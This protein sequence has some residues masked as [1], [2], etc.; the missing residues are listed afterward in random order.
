[1]SDNDTELVFLGAKFAGSNWLPSV[2]LC[3]LECYVFEP[4]K[5]FAL[6]VELSNV[7][8]KTNSDKLISIK[9][10]FYRID[11]FRDAS[12]FLKFS[13]IIRSIFTSK[14][15]LNKAKLM[16][17]N[18]NVVVNTDLK[19]VNSCTNWKIIIK[20]I[21]VDLSKSAIKAVFSKFGKIISIRMQLIDLWQKAVVEFKSAEIVCLV[22]FKWSVLVEKNSVHVAL[23]VNDKESWISRDF[24]C[25]LLYT[26]L[27][28]T[29]AHNLSDL[30][31][32]Y[33][34]KTCVIGHNFISYVRV[35]CAVI[36]FKSEAAKLAAIGLVPVFKS[37]NL[38]WAGLCLARCTKCT[39]FGYVTAICPVGGNSGVCGKRII[40]DQD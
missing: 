32:A 19:K 39:Q 35:R 12:I 29:T 40:S 34:E 37:V 30:V 20:E 22:V 27:V 26:L 8:G 15:S 10:I 9:K 33:G 25:A 28:G 1:M 3:V 24:Y 21:P 4:V 18:E 31:E 23:V 16:V 11:D 36:C 17:I 7:P 5:L 2:I 38:R 6:D 13:K 14:S